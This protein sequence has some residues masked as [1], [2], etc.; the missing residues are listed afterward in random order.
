[1][2]PKS[3]PNSRSILQ[4][5]TILLL[6]TGC[7]P[8]NPPQPLV[9]NSGT[10]FSQNAIAA[11]TTPV[12]LQQGT[13]IAIN[14]R[15]FTVAWGK[16]QQ[17]NSTR[18]G[19]SDTG[20]MQIFGLEFL[21]NQRPHQQPIHWFSS[22]ESQPVTLKA[23]LR[24]TNRYLDLSDWL[25]QQNW[26][27]S[28]TGDLLEIKTPPT[29]ILNIRQG[30]HLWGERIVVDLDRSTPWQISQTP[31]KGVVMIEGTADASLVEQFPPVVPT[32]PIDPEADDIMPIESD[33][34]PEKPLFAVETNNG[35][36]K[37]IVNLTPGY[38]LRVSTLTN[39]NR[40]V[41]DMRPD[42]LVEK[43]IRWTSGLTWHQQWVQ[44]LDKSDR[45]AVTWLEI[46][47]KNPHLIL[48]PITSNSQAAM[49]IV[50]LVTTGRSL[51]IIA[52]I[53]GGFFNR[54]NQLPLGAIRQDNN[55]LSGPILNRG[56]I[57]WTNQ[58]Q[59]KMGR[60]SLQETLII[61]NNL[62]L[63]II[64]LNTAY[65][66]AGIAR[67]T[68]TWGK[69]YTPLSDNETIVTVQNK[70]V[71]QQQPGGTAGEQT[72]AIPSRGYLL[73]IRSDSNSA[74]AL[75]IG[76]KVNLNQAT[77][78]TEFN[79]Y[80]HIIGAGPLLL[81]N[82]QIVLDTEA[83]KFSTAFQKQMASRSAIATTND[84]KLIIAAVH[85]RM[86]GKGPNLEEL[87]QILQNLG[88]INALNLDG[89]SS[90]SLYLGGQL[91]DRSAITAA[92]VNNGLGIFLKR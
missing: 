70:Q 50:P 64:L 30:H 37:I 32:E 87:A 43:H 42:P 17:G 78:P 34:E 59:I 57:A 91:I 39:P 25:Q 72:F 45:F 60:L 54:N 6:G 83:E 82:R 36:T 67:Y 2:K 56:A 21:N 9:N 31:S 33:P 61:N 86:G 13:K 7:L 55:W 46:D 11:E 71:I 84:N 22:S 51:P 4:I 1:M 27:I 69:T 76:T 3:S 58:G 85:Q 65:V 53:N 88:A 20:A 48:K 40:I 79:R 77:I 74:Q 89:G 63:P 81:Q 35:Q 16:W 66:Q 75:Q 62:S 80:P 90:T 24:K 44:I 14:G 19:I 23:H 5:L 10:V 8:Q 28:T 12:L 38:G 52:A 26:Q 49:G 18:I 47:L 73:V 92:R 15:K 68:P 41:I 29:Q